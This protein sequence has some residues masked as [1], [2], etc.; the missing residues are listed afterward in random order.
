MS[1]GLIDS[2]RESGCGWKCCSFGSGGHLVIL[3]HELD[4]EPNIRHLKI[5]DDDYF[6]GKK[7]KCVAKDCKTC[8][9]GYKPV[10]C[11]AY[12]VWVKSVSN[13][14]LIK[15][16][17]CP[18]GNESLQGHAEYVM[19][20]FE[21]YNRHTPIDSFLSKAWVNKY[22]SPVNCMQATR[23]IH[24]RRLTLLEESEIND[25]EEKLDDPKMCAK[26]TKE[27][28]YESLACGCSY[29]AF[30]CVDGEFRL[31]AYSLAYPTEYGTG[32][33]DKCFVREDYRG[34]GLQKRMLE[35]NLSAL[36]AHNVAEVFAMASTENIVSIKNFESIGFNI[37]R[38]TKLGRYDRY[39]LKWEYES[40][41]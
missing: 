35:C 28:V 41:D 32:Y 9:G 18:L 21:E 1:K 12:P 40:R 19:N 24:V 38:D 26:S 33:V 22:E 25:Y 8:D 10:M 6:G 39:I 27:D 2:C 5:I 23:E 16:S 3:P 36:C 34:K 20:I 15:S 37:V 7:A 11:R 31:I 13:R 29:G 14:I 4:D 30:E 17:R